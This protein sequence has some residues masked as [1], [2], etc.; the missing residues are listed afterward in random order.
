M[1]NL[2]ENL[3]SAV[4]STAQGAAVAPEKPATDKG[5]AQKKSAAKGR[6]L[7]KETEHTTPFDDTVTAG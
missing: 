4:S 3:T 6:K 7:P 1:T 2:A 5:A